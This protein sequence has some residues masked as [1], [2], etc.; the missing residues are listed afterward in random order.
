VVSVKN[1]LGPSCLFLYSKSQLNAL[2]VLLSGRYFYLDYC[3]ATADWIS[4]E[5]SKE[6]VGILAACS[7]PLS[8]QKVMPIN[9]FSAPFILSQVN[10]HLGFHRSPCSPHPSMEVNYHH[11][12]PFIAWLVL[13]PETGLGSESCFLCINVR[14]DPRKAQNTYMHAFSAKLFIGYHGTTDW[15][16]LKLHRTFHCQEICRKA[17]SS[18]S[19]NDF[20]HSYPPPPT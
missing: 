3:T 20:S 10:V 17:T 16:L 15:Y 9:A 5:A 11:L 8:F 13:C 12:V 7:N 4:Q 1:D 6:P 18:C 14:M 19:G 2:S